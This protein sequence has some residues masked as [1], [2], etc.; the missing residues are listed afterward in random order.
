MAGPGGVAKAVPFADPAGGTARAGGVV[1]V[2]AWLAEGNASGRRP[3]TEINCCM[4]FRHGTP[5][6]TG[7]AGCAIAVAGLNS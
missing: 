7:A 6:V 2:S 3:G 5:G 1:L 4:M